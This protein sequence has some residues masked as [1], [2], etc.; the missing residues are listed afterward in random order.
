[1]E[2]FVD[3]F[4]TLFSQLEKMSSETAILELQK[5]SLLLARMKSDY[6]LESTVAALRT[7]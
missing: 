2:T 5:A 7:K 1:M 6:A 4:K 3:E